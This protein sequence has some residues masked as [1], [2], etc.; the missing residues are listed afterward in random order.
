MERRE[1][2]RTEIGADLHVEVGIGVPGVASSTGRVLNV[3]ADGVAV[4]VPGGSGIPLDEGKQVVLTFAGSRFALPIATWATVRYRLSEGAVDRVGLEFVDRKALDEALG[5]QPLRD[6]FN[7]RRSF[8]VTPGRDTPILVTLRRDAE[9]RK[10]VSRLVDISE[11]GLGVTAEGSP[12]PRLAATEAIEM[13]F[14]LPTS[15][16]PLLLRGIVRHQRSHLGRTLYGVEFDPE[17][18]EN[19]KSRLAA[20]REFVAQ[21]QREMLRKRIS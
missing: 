12:V 18:S 13:M 4:Q 20:I 6:L 19:W 17:R 1:R 21:R 10:I 7:R 5:G 8:R 3:T 11:T 15:P 9:E 16:A 2:Y 14:Q